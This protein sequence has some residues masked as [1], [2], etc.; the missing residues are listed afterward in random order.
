MFIAEK[1]ADPFFAKQGIIGFFPLAC[2]CA[3]TVSLLARNCDAFFFEAKPAQTNKAGGQTD[4]LSP[5]CV[6]RRRIFPFSRVYSK[7]GGGEPEAV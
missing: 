6:T 5:G 4:P 1:T 7:K 3:K 2:I